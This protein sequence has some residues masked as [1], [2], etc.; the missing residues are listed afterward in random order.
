MSRRETK[1]KKMA[2]V[3][4]E[5]L[6]WQEKKAI[7][8]K[9]EENIEKEVEELH[10]WTSLLEGM[11]DEQLKDYLSKRPETTQTVRTGKIAPSKRVQK[12]PKSKLSSSSQSSS[13]SHGLMA[14]IWKFHTEDDEPL[15]SSGD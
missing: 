13:Q 11:D 15:V 9:E 6:S 10:T 1:K 4:R 8:D 2:S 3:E 12:A 7:A 14:T 5:C